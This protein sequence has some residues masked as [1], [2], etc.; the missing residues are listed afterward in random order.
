MKYN[1]IIVYLKTQTNQ[2]LQTH[3]SNLKL[4][5]SLMYVTFIN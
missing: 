4:S 1:I 5:Y 3:A 2:H